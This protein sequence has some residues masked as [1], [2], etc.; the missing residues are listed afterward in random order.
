M[1]NTSKENGVKFNI[2]KDKLFLKAKFARLRGSLLN[3]PSHANYI[4]ICNNI[5]M[6]Y[7]LF[8]FQQLPEKG[9][10]ARTTPEGNKAVKKV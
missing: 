8:I 3:M 5:L 9:K 7:D 10:G 4:K 6:C 1:S 2:E